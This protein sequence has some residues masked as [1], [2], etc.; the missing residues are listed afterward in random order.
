MR[1][2]IVIIFLFSIKFLAAQA[3]QEETIS[4]KEIVALRVEI[5]PKVD[6]VLDD[7]VWNK[8]PIATD[9]VQAQPYPGEKASQKT[10][11]RVLYD[12]TAIYIGAIL[13]DVSRDSII[14]QYSQRDR[15]D[16]T[17]YFALFIDTYN[18]KQNG[19]GFS[20]HPTGVQVDARYSQAQ[21]E[22]LS[23]NAVW[24][25]EV[26]KDDKGWYVE[27]KIPYSAIRFPDNEIQE[28]GINFQRSIRRHREQ[29][30]WNHIDPEVNG[31]VNQWGNMEGVKNIVSPVRL[32]FLPYIS[33]YL[34]HYPY[35]IEGSSNYSNSING[36]MDIK[37]GINDAFT[38][39]MTLIPDFGQVQSDNQV[40][41]LSPF[42]VKFNENRPF[43]TEGTELFNKGNLFYSRRLGGIPI[44]YSAASDNLE[45]NEEVIKNPSESQLINA[46]KISGRTK[47][48]LGIG[49]FNGVT[50]SMFA[51]IKDAVTGETREVLTDP[52]TNYSV[53]VLDQNLKNNSFASLINTN[54]TRKGSYYDANV[55]R[56]MIKLNDKKNVFSVAGGGTVSQ[57]YFTDSLSLGHTANFEFAKDGGN[58]NYGFSYYEESDTYDP[59][60]LGFLYNNNSRV[61]NITVGYNVYKPFWK[62]LRL[63]SDLD[64]DYERLYNPDKFTTLGISAEVGVDFRNFLTVGLNYRVDPIE[65]YDYFEPRVWG[66]FQTIQTSNNLGGFISSDYR[67]TIAIDIST[68]IRKFDTDNRYNARFKVGPRIRFSDKFSMQYELSL[69]YKINDERAAI[70]SSGDGT[71]FNDAIIFGKRDQTTSTSL[72]TASYIFT[73]RMGLTFRA[74]HYRSYVSYKTFHVLDEAGYLA[75]S[76]YLGLAADGS[77]LHNT[78]FNAFS[79]DMVYRWVFAPGSEL[80]LVFK[81]NLT[82]ADDAVNSSYLDN[83]QNTLESS[84]TKSI[85]LKVLYF[86]DYLSLKRKK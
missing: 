60:D 51:T 75:P 74:R 44:D 47:S 58:L 23:W 83:F 70:N 25:S 33:S 19:Y 30:N 24:Q 49:V 7:T 21:G 13:H 82:A 5:P 56:A 10:E 42:E 46:T 40:L 59:N 22:D 43:F 65:I 2:L 53:L 37:Y 54:V 48:G 81:S 50:K 78:N 16:N 17:D 15:E 27:M 69:D 85:S 84:Q 72:L 55:T 35:N 73:N 57:L 18:D 62:F 26:T 39:D 64:V 71:I 12:N 67:K 38:L 66:R 34:E 28:W 76:D 36:G 86:I 29:S 6:G 77:S 79:I 8:A 20:V 45:E 41:N 3:L 61:G 63:W 32:M 68:G 11:V 1:Y 52:L 9:F 80:S 4:K 31:F 14:S